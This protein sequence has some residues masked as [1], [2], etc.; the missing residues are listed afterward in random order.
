M[1]YQEREAKK[2]KTAYNGGNPQL[3]FRQP[4]N[5]PA[6]GG[7][8]WTVSVAFPSSTIATLATAEQRIAVPSRI[9]RALAIFSIDEVI[10]FDDSPVASRPLNTDTSAYTGDTDPCHFLTHVLS[11]LEAPPFMRKALFPLHPNLRLISSL[12]GLD[13]PHHPHPKES[14][15]YREGV[16]IAG[17]TKSSDGTLV[18]VGLEKPV[19]IKEDI[20]PKTRVTIKLS[21]DESE[22]SECVHPHAPRTETGFYWGYTVRKAASLS[23][24]FT[25]SPYE[26]GYDMSI[27]TSERG[28]PASKE[29]PHSRRLQFNHMLIVFGGPRGIEYAAMNDEELGGMGIQGGKTR[30]LFDHWVDV[31]PNQGSRTIRTEEAV[32][33]A[34]TALKR[35]WDNE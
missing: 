2:R 24:V 17:M 35:I 32:F 12:P 4:I 33:I 30:E 14:M 7:R 22:P 28:S 19:E 18:D 34:L 31:L 26:N 21:E 23:A 3:S 8:G 11:Y 5:V 29:F 25:E 9:A 27:G 16:T 13:T 15:S 6:Q 1:S 10:V 20:P